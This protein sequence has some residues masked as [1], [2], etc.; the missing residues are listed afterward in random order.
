VDGPSAAAELVL[1]EIWFGSLATSTSE[2]VSLT[3]ALWV[4][5]EGGAAD[6]MTLSC[7]C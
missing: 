5:D 2:A 1:D 6:E 4:P 7:G 3:W